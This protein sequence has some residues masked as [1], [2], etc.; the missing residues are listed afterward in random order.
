MNKNVEFKA[1]LHSPQTAREFCRSTGGT[2]IRS[3]EQ[4]DVYLTVEHGRL[5]VRTDCT[6]P[7]VL[8][9]YERSNRPG[10]RESQFTQV[11]L[12]QVSPDLV[13]VLQQSLGVRV[14]VRKQRETYKWKTH[15]INLDHV[16]DLG[17][18]IEIEVD[19]AAVGSSGG[20]QALTQTLMKELAVSE[21]DLV[22]WS[23]SDFK[24]IQL[25]AHNWRQQLDLRHHYGTLY[26]VD[27]A[28]GTGKSTIAHHLV[29]NEDLNLVSV[30]R[31]ATRQPRAD[32]PLDS[33]YVFVSRC[34]FDKLVS[35]G[36]FIEFRDFEFDMSYGIPWQE[37]ISA[38][39]AGRNALGL[40][41]LGNGRH[42]KK[43]FPEAVTILITAPRATVERRLRSRNL[44]TEA[45]IAERLRNAE[46]SSHYY[47]Y[48]D[49]VIDND[50][51]CLAGSLEKIR[52]LVAAHTKDPSSGP[53][54]DGELS[55]GG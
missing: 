31:Y 28:S 7:A 47:P 37:A 8:I 19:V 43:L 35:R 55:G 4:T 32:E 33:E 34:Q 22:P 30:P 51:G 36:A 15:L 2:L 18:F 21:A 26:L 38:L 12:D 9:Y 23:Y 29:G 5:K 25:S 39:C 17:H 44:H 11:P 53:A 20:A 24:T 52:E 1:Y 50:D 13:A 14:E 41:N 45:Q 42:I 48:Y 16:T 27:G 46:A 3:C 6:A 40:I 49:H 10:A 54:L